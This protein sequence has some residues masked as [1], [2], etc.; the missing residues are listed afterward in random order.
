MFEIKNEK[1]FQGST[2]ARVNIYFDPDNLTEK[3]NFNLISEL[4]GVSIDIFG[5]LRKS[6]NE[7]KLF[8]MTYEYDKNKKNKIRVFFDKYKMLVSLKNNTW[9]LNIDSPY[10]KGNVN[11]P[12]EN[13]E[14]RSEMA[15][16]LIHI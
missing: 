15:L 3:I 9:L 4:K 5:P 6:A 16:S 13:S 10:I 1:I 14:K 8:N 2:F 7:K 12:L 11:C